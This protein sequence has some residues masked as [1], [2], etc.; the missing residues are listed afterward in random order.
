[1][2]SILAYILGLITFLVIWLVFYLVAKSSPSARRTYNNW[3]CNF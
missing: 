3:F 2:N 1:M